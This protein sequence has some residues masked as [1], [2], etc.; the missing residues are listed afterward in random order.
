MVMESGTAMA[1]RTIVAGLL[2]EPLVPTGWSPLPGIRNG[3][4]VNSAN[5]R[6]IHRRSGADEFQASRDFAVDGA[7]ALQIEG[8][9]DSLCQLHGQLNGFSRS[10]HLAELDI[11]QSSDDGNFI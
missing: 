2:T 5:S 1:S 7:F 4:P 9:G 3:H 8:V 10:N 11:V 6:C